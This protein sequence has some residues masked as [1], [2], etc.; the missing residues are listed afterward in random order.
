MPPVLTSVVHR[1]KT[2]A[3][4]LWNA[5]DLTLRWVLGVLIVVLAV[6]NFVRD[7]DNPPHAFWDESYYLTSAERY[8][9]DTAQYASHP[10]LAFMFMDL[11]QSLTGGNKK[12]DTHFMAEVKKL[13]T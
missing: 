3:D 6:F 4:K 12:L 5:D 10:P 8:K 2:F 13:D 9:E 7:I 1:T 11:G